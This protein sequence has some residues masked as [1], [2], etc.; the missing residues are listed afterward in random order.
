MFGSALG[1]AVMGMTFV[2]DVQYGDF[3]I[4]AM[5]KMISQI[6]MMRYM[7]EDGVEVPLVMQ[8]PV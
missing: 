7:S 3:L 8:M 4:R 5:D 6:S 2:V 1:S